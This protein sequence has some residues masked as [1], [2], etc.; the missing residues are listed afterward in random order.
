MV[1]LENTQNRCGGAPLTVEYTRQVGEFA[2]SNG[3]LFHLDGARIFNA[4]VAL[5]TSPKS[6][7]VFADTVTFCLS[8][9]LSA[10]VGSVLCGP[11]EVIREARRWRKM[12]GGGMRQ[13]G[14]LAAA[15]IVALQKMTNRLEDDHRRAARLAQEMLQ[16]DQID[17][18]IGF[19][20]N[21]QWCFLPSNRIFPSMPASLQRG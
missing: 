18:E 6:L 4:A 1:V 13:A 8:K 5:K 21:Q 16:W 3:L 15:G 20:A 11:H 19:A 12:L 2:H 9:G 10:P 14:V 7:A 17:F